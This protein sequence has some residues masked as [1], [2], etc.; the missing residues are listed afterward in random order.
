[1]RHRSTFGDVYGS[2]MLYRLAARLRDFGY[3]S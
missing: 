1:M 3:H 2:I